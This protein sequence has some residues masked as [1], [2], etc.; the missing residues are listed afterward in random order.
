MKVLFN[1]K[2]IVGRIAIVSLLA[3]GLVF[4][5]M[6]SM[7]TFVPTPVVASSCCASAGQGAA[8]DD[9]SS[10]SEGCCAKE[11][12]T[13]NA[14]SCCSHPTCPDDNPNKTCNTCGGNDRECDCSPPA[15]QSCTCG[16]ICKEG[17][18][19]CEAGPGNCYSGS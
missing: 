5:G 11:G 1:T 12:S 8:S 4:A 16:K 14:G 15:G 17:K 19:S 9:V 2:S 6:F 7:N 13:I 3:G 18:Y 10:E